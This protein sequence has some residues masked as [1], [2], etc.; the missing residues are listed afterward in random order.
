MSQENLSESFTE[1]N[2]ICETERVNRSCLKGIFEFSTTFFA[3]PCH[4]KDSLKKFTVNFEN[5]KPR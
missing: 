1:G 5:T 4:W 3:F 2:R